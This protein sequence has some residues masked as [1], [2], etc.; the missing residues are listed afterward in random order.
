[1]KTMKRLVLVF[2]ILMT[3][4]GMVSAATWHVTELGAGATDGTAEANAW[5][6][7]QFNALTG[8][9]LA[10]DTIEF[11]GNLISQIYPH[12]SGTT[13][14]PVILDF[15]DV[16]KAKYVSSSGTFRMTSGSYLTIN[17]LN[18]DNDFLLGTQQYTGVLISAGVG[19]T[20]DNIIFNNSE[21][22]ES[23]YGMIIQGNVTELVVNTSLLRDLNHYGIWVR[24][25]PASWTSR[26]TNVTIQNSTFNNVGYLD[27]FYEAQAAIGIDLCSDIVIK[28]NEVY[29]FKDGYGMLAVYG[30]AVSRVLIEGNIFHGFKSDHHRSTISLKN[31]INACTSNE[32]LVIRYNHIYENWSDDKSWGDTTAGVNFS[33][34]WTNAFVYGNYIH[35]V[36]VGVQLGISWDTQLNGCGGTTRASADGIDV[37]PAYVF[38]NVISN[39]QGQG[40]NTGNGPS[41]NFD[42]LDDIYVYNNTIYRAGN[43]DCTLGAGYATCP[44][45]TNSAFGSLIANLQQQSN[46]NY[47]NTLIFES[48]PN[49]TDYVSW[50]SYVDSE[51]SV[52]D[53]NHYYDPDTASLKVQN[54]VSE[55][56]TW[57]YNNA[58]RPGYSEH[59]T[60]GD[61]SLADVTN[62]DFRLQA[63][64]PAAV[65]AQGVDMETGNI[66]TVTIAGDN[67]AIPWDF[68]LGPD[69]VFSFDVASEISI[70]VIS[71]DSE[72]AWGKGAYFY[73]VPTGDT[74]PP[75]V[76][77][78]VI[79]ATGLLLT[80][81]LSESCTNN[82]GFTIVPS[83]APA[84]L[85]YDSGT[86]S[87]RVYDISRAISYNEIVTLSY[88]A[89]SGDI[90]DGATNEIVS[91]I[92][93]SIDNGSW[94]GYGGA[95]AGPL[96][97]W[98]LA[99]MDWVPGGAVDWLAGGGG[100]PP[101]PP[102]TGISATWEFENDFTDSTNTQD[103]TAGPTT[104]SP[105][106]TAVD[107]LGGS[108]SAV[109]T[110][111]DSEYAYITDANLD[112]ENAIKSSV[113]GSFTILF[114]FTPDSVTTNERIL[115]KRGADGSGTYQFEIWIN[116]LDSK[117][118]VT[119]G[120][121]SGTQEEQVF[122]NT[123]IEAGKEY[124]FAYSYNVNT[125][126]W[127]ISIYSYEIED[128]IAT[129]YQGT[130]SSP[131]SYTAAALYFGSRLG[132]SRY[133]GGK[134]DDVTI[135]NEVMAP[136]DILDWFAPE[137]PNFAHPV[138]VAGNTATAGTQAV[139]ATHSFTILEGDLI[140]AFVNSNATPTITDNNTGNEMTEVVEG[141]A[142]PNSG[143]VRALYWRIAPD[144]SE[145]DP[146]Q[147]TL[148]GANTWR[149]ILLQFRPPAGYAFQ[150]N[151]LDV[152]PSTNMEN[153]NGTNPD[154]GP[155]TIGTTFATAISIATKDSP[156]GIYTGFPSGYT[157]GYVADDVV[158]PTGIYF[159]HLTETGSEDPSAWT[160]NVGGDWGSEVF[161]LAPCIPSGS[162]P[163]EAADYYVTQLGTDGGGDNGSITNP[164]SVAEFNAISGLYPDT[165]FIF[166]GTVTSQI[167][168]NISGDISGD[169]LLSFDETFESTHRS[170]NGALRVIDEAYITIDGFDGT[171][172][173]T[174]GKSVGILIYASVTG[175]S[176]ITIINSD[177]DNYY[178][179]LEE[180][181]E[182][183]YVTS[184][185]FNIRN[186]YITIGTY[187]NGNHLNNIGNDTGSGDISVTNANDVVI[188]YN[189]CEGAADGSSGIDG[190]KIET[191]DRV[192]V[193]YNKVMNHKENLG[194]NLGEDG[195]DLKGVT[196]GIFRYNYSYNN[197]AIGLTFNYRDAENPD[198]PETNIRVYG[199]WFQD[200]GANMYADSPG[201]TADGPDEHT[202]NYIWANVLYSS[203]LNNDWNGFATGGWM[204]NGSNFIFNN[205]FV[206]EHGAGAKFAIYTGSDALQIKNNLFYS[207]LH[208]DIIYAG[209]PNAT[210]D[211][212][213]GYYTLGDSRI[214]WNGAYS[215]FT[216]VDAHGL[217][218]NPL[219]VDPA[220]GN[221]KLGAGSP[222]INSG[223]DIPVTP[224]SITVQGVTYTFDVGVLMG[225]DTD[226]TLDPPSVT[227]VDQN[228]TPNRGAFD[229]SGEYHVTQSGTG[230][231][232]SIAEFNALTGN[233]SDIVFNFSGTFT[234]PL[235]PK[236]YG[237]SGHPVILD[238]GNVTTFTATSSA[239]SYA[240]IYFGSDGYDY[241]TVKN[242]TID[243]DVTAEMGLSY[244]ATSGIKVYLSD[245]ITV[246]NVIINEV[247]N[248]MFIY[249]S[250][251]GT[252]ITR[253]TFSN[254]AE[255]GIWIAGTSPNY[256]T[257]TIIG[258]SEVNGN[259]FYNI[260]YKSAWDS[261]LVGYDVRATEDVDGITSSYNTHYSDTTNKGMAAYLLHSCQNVLIEHNTI[262]GHR[263]YNSRPAISIKGGDQTG[264]TA[265]HT[266]YNFVVRFNKIYDI[267]VYGTPYTEGGAAVKTS[268]NWSNIYV[269]N[270]YIN[271]VIG[272]IQFN[273]GTWTSPDTDADGVNGNEGH[274]W[275][276]VIE[277]ASGY[278]VGTDATSSATDDVVNLG[279]INNT[280]Y[281]IAETQ[282]WY[283]FS[284]LAHG[285]A[286]GRNTGTKVK[287]NIFMDTRLS[288]NDKFVLYTA[289]WTNTDIDTNLVYQ[290]NA[291]TPNM[292]YD[293]STTCEPCAYNSASNPD[294]GKY[295]LGDPL[296]TSLALH[297]FSLSSATS[298]AYESGTTVTGPSSIPAAVVTRAGTFTYANL[299][300]PSV[301]LTGDAA[302][303][304]DK[305]V[306]GTWSMGAVAYSAPI[307]VTQ[308]GTGDS[309]SVAEFNALSGDYSGEIFSFTG[310]ITSDVNINVYGTSDNKVTLDGW[311]DNECTPR[312]TACTSSATVTTAAKFNVLS[313]NVIIK[314]FRW[315]Q[316]QSRA[317][318][319]GSSGVVISG[320]EIRNCGFK[321]SY[322][323]YGTIHIY[324]LNDGVIN[325]N[326]F[327]SI[328]H[329]DYGQ[330]IVM[331]GG[332]RNRIT[333][334]TIL[335]GKTYVMLKYVRSNASG[336]TGTIEDNI[337]ANNIMGSSDGTYR[338]YE[339]GLSIDSAGD[340]MD[341]GFLDWDY[342]SSTPSTTHTVTLAHANWS[343]DNGFTGYSMIFVDGPLAG[344]YRKIVS[345]SDATFTLDGDSVA[346]AAAGNLVV[347]G[348]VSEGNYYT[349]NLIYPPSF[350]QASILYYGFAFRNVAEANT[351]STRGSQGGRI[352]SRSLYDIY[353]SGTASVTNRC[354]IS[355]NGYNL[356][357]D[358]SIS[359]D[360]DIF[361]R[362]NA[363]PNSCSG[364]PGYYRTT[365]NTLIGNTVANRLYATYQNYYSATDQTANA[366]DPDSVTN[367][368][369]SASTQYDWPYIIGTPV[370]NG[371]TFNFTVSENVDMTG[372]RTG[373][374][375]LE[376]ADETKILLAYT[377]G[378][379]TTSITMTAQSA[380]ANGETW[381]LWFN[382]D[383]DSIEDADGNDMGV[384][385]YKT[386]TN[387][388]PVPIAVTQTGTGD[389]ISVAE[390]NALTGDY[391][392]QTFS[393]S[394]TITS[395]IEINI[396]GTSGY[397][398]VL[399]GYEA[400][401]YDASSEGTEAALVTRGFNGTNRTITGRYGIAMGNTKQS[402]ITIRDFRFTECNTAILLGNA[403][404][405]YAAPAEWINIENCYFFEL[406][407]VGIDAYYAS[408]IT[409]GG[410]SAKANY[411][412]N[413]ATVYDFLNSF[414]KVIGVSGHDWVVSY[415]KFYATV[416]NGALCDPVAAAGWHSYDGLIEYNS[417]LNVHSENA[418]DLKNGTH[419]VIVRKN[420]FSGHDNI[421]G[422]LGTIHLNDASYNA[423]IYAN[424]FTNNEHPAIDATRDSHDHYIFSNVFDTLNNRAI[425]IY[426]SFDAT[427]NPD[428]FYIYGNT[429]Y[430]GTGD[431]MWGLYLTNAANNESYQVKNNIIMNNEYGFGR[432]QVRTDSTVDGADFAYN[433]YYYDGSTPLFYDTTTRTFAQWQ[434]AGFDAVGSAETDPDLNSD[435]EP[436]VGSPVLATGTVLSSAG[437]PTI[438]IQGNDYG[439]SEAGDYHFGY[440]VALDPDATD[441]TTTPPTVGLN[442]R[443]TEGGA[444]WNKG[445]Y[446]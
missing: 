435:L 425:Q 157:E 185:F 323:A 241:I 220:N 161:S 255:S 45:V 446:E 339:E 91:F 84:T 134:L 7:V 335:G 174:T 315:T 37:G 172:S 110:L 80:I 361:L 4:V 163:P 98:S 330:N 283:E 224:P 269:Y 211:Y 416:G 251:N 116:G 112:S 427:V 129:D 141:T 417:F 256:P 254:I 62:H 25:H 179:T 143:G 346:T 395:E 297:D 391:S 419:D 204:E 365:G 10:G 92:G 264:Y 60:Q 11:H 28:N 236:I 250:S 370:I 89:A 127:R 57:D 247:H 6:L 176:H 121:N 319:V 371:S 299:I 178:S 131:L 399:D 408:N 273:L 120:L 357:K 308:T 64:S 51:G 183:I 234:T 169:V 349:N 279:F 398:V 320:T 331:G 358:N 310:A 294:N 118:W 336:S 376:D 160:L 70:D 421:G 43:L 94:V 100:A 203:N 276:N 289:D 244:D 274:A 15:S 281:D 389:S 175:C 205:T 433:H 44:F 441:W 173:G 317:I 19:D 239:A 105:T 99:S 368:T 313:N 54:Y 410:A 40:I 275:G 322:P 9:A 1:M 378:T 407:S 114:K 196:D 344:T 210:I 222:A 286:A 442:D 364:L 136:V 68:A 72:G 227:W 430:Q 87:S 360:L 76:T 5:S 367:S 124:G 126:A 111:A 56:V 61:P 102:P 440:D 22:Y 212:N 259:T 46:H 232:I 342:I 93:Y 271:N 262:H 375:W 199:N 432:E 266:A 373:D 106:F 13:G 21:I 393:F 16:L 301:D 189:V 24:N 206:N 150:T 201:N 59:A 217:M 207:N 177:L 39:T 270:N 405:G 431:N 128:L 293:G 390:F 278:C 97:N 263:S 192:L 125:R 411:F 23:G 184:S 166:S 75:V 49:S 444:T 284:G 223:L 154:A 81:T 170:E 198:A 318:V 50:R 268:G 74:T 252:T 14:S 260:T 82:A 194:S 195:F 33:Y 343:G 316:N 369:N 137:I 402:Y 237:T 159:K 215:P 226:F 445:A 115:S 66:D 103:L 69:T 387:N 233:Y 130:W 307:E 345:Q 104:Q 374:M 324:C 229:Y 35:D 362:D 429:I 397:P 415:N 311:V 95:S 191:T 77:N 123:P 164:Y 63:G 302:D 142:A 135:V 287:N 443:D 246:D 381:Y 109:F 248:G 26:P 101:P 31:D 190:I 258:G 200:N 55:W 385:G 231:A 38:A 29:N 58:S 34:N 288:A 303:Y 436:N 188:A 377:S 73:D 359:N 144:G 78:A 27:S 326:L 351:I 314:N 242:L 280:C 85:V 86:G 146:Y 434:T 53:Y 156:T 423:V 334:N 42:S 147:W 3:M 277:S 388:T 90:V 151:P 341:T 438:T 355:P 132:T 321:G 30:N 353:D 363:T 366:V 340:S 107:P 186:N 383:D 119:Q 285:L 71:W 312:D 382:G 418:I 113:A 152:S 235:I 292:F 420:I 413:V 228:G 145:P 403:T 328:Y 133:Y 2:L 338:A 197:K 139:S 412:F 249:N 155:I 48:R 213:L 261:N 187:G 182:G 47:E 180:K 295:T 347:I 332:K 138:F 384:Y 404:I 88:T 122:H 348:G 165:E 65:K 36:G 406:P 52:Y 181:G 221:F 12:L 117:M 17:Y 282:T 148:S 400:G 291:A 140:L 272:G 245:N 208:N 424:L 396:S 304:I 296:F 333:N 267:N 83:G 414:E 300:S 437:L 392:G 67:Y 298:P 243:Q 350:Y 162:A 32:D 305:V 394:G 354:G 219:L 8:A 439:P 409:I 193:E 380:V 158:R 20:I 309:I 225:E 209:W 337:V 41:G 372:Y 329:A 108:Y 352:A 327:E 325:N 216:T 253:S 168:V 379:G 149:V 306:T 230:D 79:N 240:S 290:S 218:S 18:I 167:D 96:L 171:P 153:G 356:I 238:G 265:S 426:R 202:N 386:V 257:N 214:Y 401:S 428:D 422:S